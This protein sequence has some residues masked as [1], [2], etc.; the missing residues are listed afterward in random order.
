MMLLCNARS[1]VAVAFYVA[2]LTQ[3]AAAQPISI[4]ESSCEHLIEPLGIGTLQPRLTWTID[5]AAGV[6]NVTQTAYQILVASTPSTLDANVGDVFDSGVVPSNDSTNVWDGPN[7]LPGQ[8]YY[9]KVRVWSSAGQSNY[10]APQRFGVALLSKGDWMPSAAL[11]GMGSANNSQAPWLRTTFNLTSDDI[12]AITAGNASAL[13]HVASIGYHEA[14]VNGVR[15]E[16]GSVLLP[17]T[18]QLGR[19][20]PSHTY[21]ASTALVPGLNSLALWIGPGWGLFRSVNPAGNV[22]NLT[23]APLAM[24]QLRIQ[25]PAGGSSSGSGP[26]RTV[27]TDASWKVSLSP[28]S[29]LGQWVSADFGGDSYDYRLEVDGWNLPGF[30]DSG[31]EAATAYPDVLSSREIVPEVIEPT[32]VLGTVQ[33]ANVTSCASK[34]PGCY[35]VSMAELY[36]GWLNFSNLQ[37]YTDG[38]SGNTTVTLSYSTNAGTKVEYD[39]IDQVTVTTAPVSQYF[40]GKFAY[41]EIQYIT[42]EGL[43][44]PPALGD[45]TGLRLMTHRQRLGTFTCSNPLL[46]TIYD[47]T[48]RTYEGLTTGGMTVDCPHRERLGYGGDGHTSMEIAMS[49][50][51][52]PG[53]FFGKWSRDWADVQD[54]NGTADGS[55]PHTAPTID[56]GGGPG[57]GGFIV[58]MPWHLYTVT[59]D[60]RMLTDAFPHM[61]RFL[62]FLLSNVNTN[63]TGPASNTTGLMLPFGG[64]WGFL[65]DWL[66]P[67]GSEESDSIE[68]LLFNN[69]YL[70]YCLRLAVR[71]ANILGNSTVAAS[72]TAAATSIGTAVHSFFYNAS[73]GAYLDGRQSHQVMPL[74]AG[75]VPSSLIPVVQSSLSS[76]IVV[77]QTGH[78]DT[79]LHGTYFMAKLLADPWAWGG[80][81]AGAPS[82][83]QSSA[84]ASSAVGGSSGIGSGGSLSPT[85][86]AGGGADLLYLMSSATTY[87][88]YGHLLAEGYTTW[89]EDWS[90]APS[91]M[92]G[93]FNGFGLWFNTGILGVRPDPAAPGYHTALVRPSYGVG[94]VTWA[95]GSTVTPYGLLSNA[96]TVA[97]NGQSANYTHTLSIPP[98]SNALVWLPAAS[99]ADVYESGAPASAAVGVAYRGMDGANASV[100]MVSSGNFSFASW[101]AMG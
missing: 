35:V 73:T 93:C 86:A 96:W 11:I 58:T 68:A 67:H 60:E 61:V 5:A 37:A 10:S 8:L 97:H 82:P 95:S 2:L 31:W 24:A 66:T 80:A 16:E 49:T 79:G 52:R 26:N 34:E 101:L 72:F 84:L 45:L 19:V 43:T 18:A 6:R 81:D 39:M 25:P 9:W 64:S 56:G 28:S 32:R 50:Y 15:L 48:I 33:A 53:A 36:T 17:S 29:H 40:V 12:A 91:R 4:S 57:W 41:H 7:L 98:N 78:L 14:Y 87:P 100:W 20:I 74:V 71:T 99:S 94:N 22:W 90:G 63:G 92:H 88:S 46:T 65:G 13:F 27:V 55:L 30:D 69:C 54:W 21:D 38:G 42:I 70:V 77:G 23:K 83:M 44:S 1:A 47:T 75:I 51:A 3:T 62:Q 76:E 89:P 85:S 59:G